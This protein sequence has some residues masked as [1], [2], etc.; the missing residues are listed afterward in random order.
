M[1][2]SIVDLFFDE[3]SYKSEIVRLKK[4]IESLGYDI[5]SRNSI[6]AHLKKEIERLRNL[7]KKYR[8][9]RTKSS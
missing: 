2:G 4:E 9:G 1:D 5:N 7:C 3:K 8:D 6:N